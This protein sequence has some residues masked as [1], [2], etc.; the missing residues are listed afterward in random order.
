MPEETVVSAP[1]GL[2]VDGKP[3][4]ELSLDELASAINAMSEEGEPIDGGEPAV[5]QQEAP[6]DLEPVSDPSGELAAL[7]AEVAAVNK[8]LQDRQSTID[9][10]GQE[11]GEAR[12]RLSEL[13]TARTEETLYD[14][15][16]G[17]EATPANTPADPA[18]TPAPRPA[19]TSPDMGKAVK[20]YMDERLAPVAA[21]TENMTNLM[22]FMTQYPE[23][24]QARLS[25]MQKVSDKDPR[26]GSMMKVDPGL[27][28]DYVMAKVDAV[29][30]RRPATE[31]Q[32]EEGKEAARVAKLSAAVSGQ[33]G[34][35][36]AP[37]PI[38]PTKEE[39]AKMSTAEMEKKGLV[40]LDPN[41]PV[42]R[43]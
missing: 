16:S 18:P 14:A 31:T 37:A 1:E 40:P 6:Q 29:Q 22:N 19:T 7:R 35:T 24:W 13:G 21:A 30:A 28:Y 34:S 27:A 39:L 9:R 17:T 15:F 42:G 20:E 26:V 23:D 5:M 38:E 4:D 41:N 33:G 10:Q 32:T 3:A 11:L 12:A 36:L 8:R 25:L 43:F 2:L